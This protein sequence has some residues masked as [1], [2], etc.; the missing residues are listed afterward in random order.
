M[1][2]LK[3]STPT[4]GCDGRRRLVSHRNESYEAPTTNNG[5]NTTRRLLL[6]AGAALGG[7]DAPRGGVHQHGG[8]HAAAARR[9]PG[10]HL[11]GGPPMN[12]RV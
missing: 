2:E 10:P 7:G 1:T 5:T 3:R 8:A 12:A 6:G 11:P 4:I 9:T